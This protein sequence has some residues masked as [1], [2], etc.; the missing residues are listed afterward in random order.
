MENKKN[1]W[2]KVCHMLEVIR[3]IMVW[4]VIFIAYFYWQDP[5]LQINILSIWIVFPILWL[6]WIE[7][8]FFSKSA[9][10][11]SWYTPSEYQKQSAIALLSI[12]VIWIL[13]YVLNWSIDTK[14][15]ILLLWLTFV[16]FS[17]INHFLSAVIH[18]N[19]NKRNVIRPIITLLLILSILPILLNFWK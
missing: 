1:I 12:T 4:V 5:T 7:W 14:L 6:S 11:I 13:T 3:W 17:G 2:T 15:T 19:H 18:K 9:S 10:S 8:L 16:F